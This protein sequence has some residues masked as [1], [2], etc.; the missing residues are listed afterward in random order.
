MTTPS[1]SRYI[2]DTRI[3]ATSY[4]AASRQ[5]LAWARAG[6]TRS[7]FCANVHMVMESFDH[8]S[9]R[10]Q[11]NGAD[12]VTSDGMPLVWALRWLGIPQAT[13]VYGP[14]L[15]GLLLDQAAAEGLRVG[16]LGAS[17]AALD[18]LLENLRVRHPTLLVS[19]ACSPPFRPPTSGEDAAIIDRI[20][21]AAVQILFVGLGCPKQERWIAE[22]RNRLRPVAVAVGA[23][24]DLLA[25][26]QPQAPHWMQ[27]SGFEWL[28]RLL[29]EPRRLWRRYLSTNPRFL[30]HFAR[31]LLEPRHK[32]PVS[33]GELR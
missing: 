3:D 1:P 29:T 9:F 14:D 32:A 11:I 24:F 30:W 10:N 25:H 33:R 4:A 16:F 23:A 12:L 21:S 7:V 31:Q 18:R 17:P 20:N 26:T 27:A 22:H 13:R 5:V 2:L 28:F 8:P 15:T 19:F 6:E